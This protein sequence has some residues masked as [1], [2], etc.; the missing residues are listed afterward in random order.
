MQ[1]TISFPASRVALLAEVFVPLR[2]ILR[3]RESPP[4]G[5]IKHRWRGVCG[6][7]RGRA[8]TIRA[9]T[10][11]QFVQLGLEPLRGALRDPL[12][13]SAGY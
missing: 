2:G 13:S 3:R 9:A 6:G 5:T 4:E 8:K 10:W 11:A 1:E 7:C 12:A